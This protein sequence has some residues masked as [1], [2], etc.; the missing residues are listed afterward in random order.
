M[1]RRY[2]LKATS[3]VETIVALVILV[4]VFS[5]ITLFIVSIEAGAL[6]STRTRAGNI[7]DN[8]TIRTVGGKLYL[9]GTENEGPFHLER[10]VTSYGGKDSLLLIEC[11][12]FDVDHVLLKKKH[13]LVLNE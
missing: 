9:P 13:I 11:R 5:M 1:T 10:T 7:L 6:N 2:R 8:Y 3:L 12:I 4:L